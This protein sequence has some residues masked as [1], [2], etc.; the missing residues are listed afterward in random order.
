MGELKYFSFVVIL[1]MVVL[2][3]LEINFIKNKNV[4][5]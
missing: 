5:V 3:P 1:H 2:A 4:K